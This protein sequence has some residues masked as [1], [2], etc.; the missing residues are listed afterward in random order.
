MRPPFFLPLNWVKYVTQRS[1]AK[2]AEVL[3]GFFGGT[4][5]QARPDRAD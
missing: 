3:R 5:F 2:G 4:A 1:T